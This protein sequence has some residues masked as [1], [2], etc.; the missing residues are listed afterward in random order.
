M[1]QILKIPLFK[2]VN[3]VTAKPE[4]ILKIIKKLLIETNFFNCKWRE[5]IIKNV[6]GGCENFI[7]IGP[8]KVLPEWLKEQ[9][10]M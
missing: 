3:N 8:G 9:L 10:K 5:S 2:F 6:R 7:E 4:K 1:I